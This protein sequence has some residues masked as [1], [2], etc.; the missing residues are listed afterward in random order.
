MAAQ[1]NN[2]N[3]KKRQEQKKPKPNTLEA[4]TENQ[5]QYIRSIIENDYS[6][7]EIKHINNRAKPEICSNLLKYDL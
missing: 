3:R 4:K 5:K 6:N 7:I 2:N 1:V